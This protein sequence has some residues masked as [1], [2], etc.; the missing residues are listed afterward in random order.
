FIHRI[1][2]AV[3]RVADR[4]SFLLRLGPNP[5]RVRLDAGMSQLP[6]VRI[7]N[8]RTPRYE[9]GDRRAPAVPSIPVGRCV[10]FP[11]LRGS[12]RPGARSENGT[13]VLQ[14]ENGLTLER[15]GIIL[16]SLLRVTGR[17]LILVVTPHPLHVELSRCRD[18]ST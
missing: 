10:G 13:G 11:R 17:P 14:P 4:I 12:D 15:P 3:C 1:E 7:F 5:R 9:V 6:K 16:L 18:H 2:I 8:P